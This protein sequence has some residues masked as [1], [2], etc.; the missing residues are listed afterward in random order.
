MLALCD[1]LP[2]R[3]AE[4]TGRYQLHHLVGRRL[5]V[6]DQLVGPSPEIIGCGHLTSPPVGKTGS[7]VGQL[8]SSFAV[9]FPT[10]GNPT[11]SDEHNILCGKEV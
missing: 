9:V 10:K 8:I 7:R 5:Q 6:S 1:L 3:P 2:L 4:L 11:D